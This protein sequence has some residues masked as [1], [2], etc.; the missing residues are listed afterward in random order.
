MVVL[1]L[2]YHL[3]HSSLAVGATLGI[4]S[5]VQILL[6]PIG[7]IAADRLDRPRLIAMSYGMSGLA[8]GLLWWILR[9]APN[10]PISHPLIYILYGVSAAAGTLVSPAY[11]TLMTEWV[12]EGELVR[13]EGLLNALGQGFWLSGILLTGLMIT[14]T[15]PELWLLLSVC[16]FLGAALMMVRQFEPHSFRPKRQPMTHRV[17]KEIRNVSVSLYLAWRH[18]RHHPFIW[19]FAVIISLS[20]IPH[21]LLLSLPFF[22]AMNLHRGYGGFG[23][24]ESCIVLGVVIG[25]VWIAKRIT[26]YRIRN[27]LV[28]AFFTQSATC[29]ILWIG[30]RSSFIS[31]LILLTTYGA[32]DAL[33][34]P[35]YAHL[36]IV[37]PQSVRGQVFGLFNLVALL[38]TPISTVGLGWLLTITSPSHVILALAMTFALLALLSGRIVA[39][40]MTTDRE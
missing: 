19:A 18:L 23:I 35:A 34:T 2:V 25:N 15:G 3:S 21:N 33:F 13:W 32:T 17:L 38:A 7:G 37:A 26:E 31:V 28:L 10:L 36:S 5:A 20:N 27:L 6:A 22:L 1:Y 16:L 30:A 9:Y 29:L 12:T 39:F 4:P 40:K 8:V 11:R 24:L 14:F